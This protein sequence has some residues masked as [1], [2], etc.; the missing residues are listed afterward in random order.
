MKDYELVMTNV[1]E[2]FASYGDDPREVH[3][4]AVDTE[5]GEKVARVKFSWPL[6]QAMGL[7]R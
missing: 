3:V 6:W 5:T 1:Y 4:V 2:E 7:P